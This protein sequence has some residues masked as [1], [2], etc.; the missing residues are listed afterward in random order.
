MFELL[1]SWILVKTFG[2]YYQGESVLGDVLLLILILWIIQILLSTKDLISWYIN[3]KLNEKQLI[4][5]EV[6][7]LINNKFP[8]PH[9]TF[10]VN[11]PSSYFQDITTN[12]ELSPE[13]RI[14][15]SQKYMTLV[16]NETFGRIIRSMVLE[17]A[18]KKS[19]QIYLNYCIKKVLIN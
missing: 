4:D 2:N 7:Y 6:E 13:L 15:G 12:E 8:K 17:N 11:D 3:F 10:D 16:L 18:L 9:E 1:I 5:M 14:L 19:L